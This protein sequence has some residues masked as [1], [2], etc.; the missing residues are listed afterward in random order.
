MVFIPLAFFG[1]SDTKKKKKEKKNENDFDWY[2]KIILNFCE[3]LLDGKPF[4][5]A[6]F[7]EFYYLN[8]VWRKRLT[9]IKVPL[10]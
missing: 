6:N 10:S 4:V 1:D 2:D 7:L 3:A 8:K 5:K 9:N